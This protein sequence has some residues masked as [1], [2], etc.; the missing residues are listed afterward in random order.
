MAQGWVKLHRRFLDWE[1]ADNPDM[2]ALWIHLLLMS[3]HDSQ[4]WHGINIERG[5]CLTGRLKLAKTTGLSPQSIRTCLERLKSTN[6]ITIKS[7][8]QYSIITICNYDKYQTISNRT[9][10]QINQQNNKPSTNH[11]PAINHKQECKEL[12]NEKKIGSLCKIHYPTPDSP[13][14]LTEN[15][16]EKLTD[17]LGQERFDFLTGE[18]ASFSTNKPKQF[19]EYNSHY[20]TLLN[21]NKMKIQDGKDFYIHEQH[22]PGYYKQPQ[23]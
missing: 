15:E 11:Q 4:K 19:R 14:L 1:W 3:N 20:L 2:V 22:G 6:E 7:T 16:I 5:Q 13:V 18:L 8:S 9:N 10:Q 21:W 23:R 17:A 12:K